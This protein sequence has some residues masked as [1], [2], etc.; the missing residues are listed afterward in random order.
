MSFDASGATPSDG[1]IR[2]TSR[3]AAGA[4]VMPA[5]LKPKLALLPL[6]L[7]IIVTMT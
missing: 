6:G 5:V 7:S 2:C 1:P 4:I 3:F